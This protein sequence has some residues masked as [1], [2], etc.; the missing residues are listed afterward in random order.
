[1]AAVLMLLGAILATAGAALYDPRAGLIVLGAVT[2]AAG[3][4]LGR[5]S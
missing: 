5:S 1:M 4:D 2:L 3:V